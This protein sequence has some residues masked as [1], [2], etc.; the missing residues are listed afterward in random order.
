M[1]QQMP[2]IRQLP[3]LIDGDWSDWS[4]PEVPARFVVVGEQNRSG[5]EDLDASYKLAWDEYSLYIAAKIRDDK[6]V[7]NARVDQIYKGDSL[8]ILLDSNFFGDFDNATLNNDDYQIVISPGMAVP[9]VQKKHFYTF[10]QIRLVP[11]MI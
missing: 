8:E 1:D 9:V 10:L 11:E 3:L 6:Y 4:S 2:F 7:Q 5:I